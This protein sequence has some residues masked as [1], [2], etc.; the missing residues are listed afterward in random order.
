MLAHRLL[1]AQAL[2]RTIKYLTRCDRMISSPVGSLA[3]LLLEVMD[4]EPPLAQRAALY[5]ILCLV[6][7]L[8]AR[9]RWWCGLTVLPVA[10]TFGLA[11]MSELRDPFVGPAII[12]EAGLLHV[13]VWYALILSSVLIPTITAAIVRYRKSS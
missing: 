1:A 12:S 5:G 8:L 4:K 10:I 2:M 13:V 9:K 7:V 6:R 11:D 3:I